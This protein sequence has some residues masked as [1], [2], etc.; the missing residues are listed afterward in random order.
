MFPY[1]GL[2]FYIP[3][4]PPAEGAGLSLSLVRVATRKGELASALVASRGISGTVA[5][6]AA[7]GDKPSFLIT[8]PIAIGTG[9]LALFNGNISI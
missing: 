7:Q 9:S 6:D 1:T 2:C 5:V 4:A 8:L 3:L